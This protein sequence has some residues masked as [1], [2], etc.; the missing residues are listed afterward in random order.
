MNPE[1]TPLAGT[2]DLRL[3]ALSVVLAALTPCAGFE[4]VERARGT[5]GWARTGWIAIGGPAFG[6]GLCGVTDI[7]IC[8]FQPSFPVR[9]HYPTLLLALVAAMLAASFVTSLAGT[10]IPYLC[11]KSFR[12][13]AEAQFR[14]GLLGASAVFAFLIFLLVLVLDVSVLRLRSSFWRRVGTSAAVG[15][16]MVLWALCG[17]HTVR[18]RPVTGE[19]ELAHTFARSFSALAGI[20]V[21][22]LLMASGTILITTL[23]RLFSMRDEL[24][25]KAHERE[26]FFN[27][28]AEAIPG[29]VWIAD[30]KGRTTYINRHWYEMT[31]PIRIRVWVLDGWNRFIPMIGNR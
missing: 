24:F 19:V 8:A 11:L 25:A 28:L 3:L 10:A 21:A 1:F 13:A 12:M 20:A 17:L 4:V 16:A 31:A 26:S 15:A 27:N 7:A 9:Y 6:I 23:S 29:I 2:Y 30:D 14:W 5:R 22:T 18:F